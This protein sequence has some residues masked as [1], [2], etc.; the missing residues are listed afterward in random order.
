MQHSDRIEMSFLSDP[1]AKLLRWT[2]GTQF[3]T[4]PTSISR[5]R[6]W[7]RQDVNS[8]APCGVP[9][10][11]AGPSCGSSPRESRPKGLVPR[12]NAGF[13]RQAAFGG[14]IDSRALISIRCMLD[15]P[16]TFYPPTVSPISSS[17][18][19]ISHFLQSLIWE[20]LKSA[21]PSTASECLPPA[22]SLLLQPSNHGARH[23]PQ[24][25]SRDSP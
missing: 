25:V 8:R 22:H 11:R 3:L 10:C 4:R 14:F 9:C 13:Q 2:Q 18:P 7:G 16:T 6:P 1:T 19:P 23:L 5:I 21:P 20:V 12:A 17:P 15:H 24:A